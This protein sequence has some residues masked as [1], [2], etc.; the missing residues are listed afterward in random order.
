MA[1]S[2]EI[3]ITEVDGDNLIL[4][5]RSTP[6]HSG[7]WSIVGQPTL[8]VL[9]YTHIPEV[10][11]VIWGGDGFVQIEAGMGIDETIKYTR[12]GYTQLKEVGLT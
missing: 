2:A 7:N 9:N 12:I 11:Q 1:I 5:L 10:G 4:H 6:E 8:T 3:A